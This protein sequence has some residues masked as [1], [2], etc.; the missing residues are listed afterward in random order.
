MLRMFK[1]ISTVGWEAY[2]NGGNRLPWPGLEPTSNA[3]TANGAPFAPNTL[4]LPLPCRDHFFTAKKKI[5][6]YIWLS[7]QTMPKLGF[8]SRCMGPGVF[9]GGGVAGTRDRASYLAPA[10]PPLACP[11]QPTGGD[12]L[13]KRNG[14]GQRGGGDP[15]SL[16]GLGVGVFRVSFVLKNNV[17]EVFNDIERDVF[18]ALFEF[19]LG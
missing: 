15:P 3:A 11:L 1:S 14:V 5:L 13:R 10:Q 9:F 7:W 18:H 17:C 12:A 4:P 6:K 8:A 19:M 16:W 2:A